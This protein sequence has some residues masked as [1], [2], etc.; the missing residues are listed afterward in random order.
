MS[1]VSDGAL[2]NLLQDL[3]ADRLK[4]KRGA[5]SGFKAPKQ[6]DEDK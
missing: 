2:T 6:C 4:S 1:S 3:G 5:S